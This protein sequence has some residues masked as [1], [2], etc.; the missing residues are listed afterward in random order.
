MEKMMRHSAV[1]VAGIGLLACMPARSDD[2]VDAVLKEVI[3]A[4]TAAKTLTA[5]MSYEMSGGMSQK[6]AAKIK[7]MKPNLGRLDIPAPENQVLASDGKTLIMYNSKMNQ[8][9]KMPL[10]GGKSGMLVPPDSPA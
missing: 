9:M 7:L 3:T 5:D 8:Y 1:I 2:A 4:E 6:L 10:T